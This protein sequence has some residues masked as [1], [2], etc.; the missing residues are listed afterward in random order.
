M[1]GQQQQAATCGLAAKSAPLDVPGGRFGLRLLPHLEAVGGGQSRVGIGRD[2]QFEEVWHAEAQRLGA[3]AQFTAAMPQQLEPLRE[4]G[5]L[6]LPAIPAQPA[7]PPPAGARVKAAAGVVV[8]LPAHHDTHTGAVTGGGV[9]R[10]VDAEDGDG[11]GHR[12][13]A[14]GQ[15]AQRQ[16]TVE[17]KDYRPHATAIERPLAVDD[18]AQVVDARRRGPVVGVGLG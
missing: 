14:P 13:V 16:Q 12:V 8:P 18:L 6:P 17:V 5:T 10:L 2:G 7:Q 15:I 1:V 9:A 11:Y 3:C 4:Y